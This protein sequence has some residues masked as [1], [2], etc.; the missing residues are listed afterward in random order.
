MTTKISKY[1]AISAWLKAARKNKKFTQKDLA[2]KLKISK[3]SLENY[4]SGTVDVPTTVTARVAKL[5]DMWPD[6]FNTG[7][8]GQM[9]KVEAKRIWGSINDADTTAK[10]I[11]LLEKNV[12]KLEKENEEL[13]LQLWKLPTKQLKTK[14]K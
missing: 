4:E 2:F 12:E 9:K 7:D 10:Y 5:C 6:F 13:K 3:R 8:K 14:K 1:S 11:L